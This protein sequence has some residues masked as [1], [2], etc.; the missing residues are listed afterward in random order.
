MRILLINTVPTE[1]NGITNVIFNYQQAMAP[2]AVRMDYVAIRQPE[3]EYVQKI[4]AAGGKLHVIPRSMRNVPGYIRA[5][6]ALIREGK[7]DAVHAHGNSATLALEMMAAWLGGCKVRIAHSHNTTCKH[8]AVH[9]LFTPVFQKLCT[10]RLACGEDAGKW[11]YGQREFTVMHNGV[12]TKRF[13]F[14][15][16]ARTAIRR[17][18]AVA[19]DTVLV[20]HVGTF[21][22]QKNQSFLLDV[23]PYLPRDRYRLL[24]IGDGELRPAVEQRAEEMGL[25]DRVIFTGFV[26]DIP[27]YLSACDCIGMPSLYEGLPL[28][29]MEQQANGLRCVV[30]DHITREVNKTGNLTFLSLEDASLWAKHIQSLP[31]TD[32]AALSRTAGEIIRSCGYDIHREAE[33]LRKYYQQA[34][35][36]P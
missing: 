34:V 22:E 12:D 4:E 11:L 7:Y 3:P 19:E 9:K 13:A 31:D 5:L 28:A 15:P 26:S 6:S 17:Q 10:H 35:E 8:M 1:K 29:L 33:K 14:D 30:S 16:E 24:L 32:R 36:E 25:T 23:L 20:G 27:Q 18:Y 2:G 21:N